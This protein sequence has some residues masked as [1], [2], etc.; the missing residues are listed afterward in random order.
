MHEGIGEMRR[1]VKHYVFRCRGFWRRTQGVAAVEFAFMGIILLLIIGG[2]IDF[3]HAF[4]IKQV[5]TN[6]S[7]E[8]ARYAV[9]FQVD[10]T[11]TRIPPSALTPS[12]SSYV[13]TKYI[14]QTLV[15][16]LN[17]T[18]TVAGA[19]LNTGVKGQ[20]V[21]VTV[22]ATKQW[23]MLGGLSNHNFGFMQIANFH[24]PSTLSATSVM[25]CE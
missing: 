19:G 22:T 20:P 5:V 18:V 10:T 7:R 25:Q 14:S 17:P 8:G 21:Q 23:F 16:G 15:A 24:L 6:A 9:T 13:I 11:A 2:I 1:K 12:I 4:Y 3:G